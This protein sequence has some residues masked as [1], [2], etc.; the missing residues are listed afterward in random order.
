MRPPEK[1]THHLPLRGRRPYLDSVIRR[2]RPITTTDETR[3]TAAACPSCGVQASGRFCRSCGASLGGTSPCPRCGNALEAKARFC[4]QCGAGTAAGSGILGQNERILWFL[5]GGVV[6]ALTGGLALALSRGSSAA[7]T[8]AAAEAPFAGGAVAGGPAPDISNLT[9]RERFDRL[10]DRVMRAAE[11]GDQTTVTNFSP[12]ALSA[13]EML[14][15]AD[16][17][18]D[19]RYHA[20]L[21]RLHTGDI[22]GARALADTILK[23]QPSHLFGIVMRGTIARFQKDQKALDRSYGDFLAHYDAEMKV[24]RPEY[25]AHPR[26]LEEFLKAAR[27]ARGQS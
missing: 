11:Q 9:P 20:G 18:G 2:D 21:I 7:G 5:A 26:A 8:P 6:V 16:V 27:Q 25:E 10:F 15:V 1:A 17:D 14:E 13:Y 23:K 24:K 22:E 12:M 19:A 3:V 4:S